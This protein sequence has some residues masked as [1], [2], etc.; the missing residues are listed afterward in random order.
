MEV[1]LAMR[2][3]NIR[4]YAY[5]VLVGLAAA[6]SG[7]PLVSDG[8]FVSVAVHAQDP[9]WQEIALD[10]SG[11]LRSKRR[12][13][14]APE[15]YKAFQLNEA[16]LAALLAEAP[17]EFTEAAKDPRN[18]IPLPMPDGKFTRFRFVE[19]PIMEPAL[20]AQF[21]GIKTYRGWSIDDPAMT[22][23][24]A[25]TSGGFHA[26]V[27]GA[28]GAAY[29]TPLSHDDTRIHVSY[30]ARDAGADG[31]AACL[32]EPGE[33][34]GPRLDG[35][36]PRR[37]GS[38]A[39]PTSNGSMLR[40]FRLAVAATGE[41]TGFFG[42]TVAGAMNNGIVP[43]INAVTAVYQR[44]LA[45]SFM[46]VGSNASIIFTDPA[47]DGYSSGNTTRL[48][49]E[50]QS[51]LDQ[52]IGAGNYD[53][54]HVFDLNSVGGQ[55]RVGSV[56]DGGDKGRGT[57]G[58]TNPTAGFPFFFDRM[59]AHEFGHQ[60]GAR[61]T[62]NGTVGSCA[63]QRN[64]D[65]AYEP[66]S[67][68]T[69]MAYAGGCGSDAVIIQ[70]D[71]SQFSVSYFHGASLETMA[72]YLNNCGCGTTTNNNN[73]LP[74][75][76][77]PFPSLGYYLIP[78]GTPFALTASATDAED[79]SLTYCWEDLDRG[80][81]GPPTGDRVD[82]PLFRS[83]PPTS[84]PTRTFPRMVDILNGT[85]TLG[86][87]LPTTDRW[88]GFRV[89]ARDNHPGGGGFAWGDVLVNVCWRSTP[90]AVTAPT[91][92]AQA[93][94]GD[95]LTVTWDAAFTNVQPINTANVRILLSTDGGA[96]FPITL[97]ASAPNNGSFTG[98]VPH[99]HTQQARIKVEAIGNIFFNVSPAFTI[100]P[101]PT[102]TASG[103]LAVTKGGPSVTAQVATVADERDAANLLTVEQIT[104]PLTGVGLSFA[105]NNGVVSATATAQCVSFGGSHSIRLRVTNSAGLSA[106]TTL[107]LTVNDDPSPTLGAYSN[108]SVI[109]GQSVTISPSAAPAD[110][111]N[112]LSGI[113]VWTTTPPLSATL[114]TDL[115]TGR[116]TIRTNNNTQTKIYEMRVEVRD[117]C[118][119][120]IT[121]GFFLTVLNSPPQITRNANSAR[122]TQGGTSAAPI[123]IATVSDLQDAAGDL[124]VSAIAPAG[125]T[126][127][128]TNSNGAVSATAIATC[129]VA[130]ATYNATLTVT[131]S[132]G[133][134]A[135]TTF[136]IIV[137][138]N[139]PPTLGVYFDSG[140][141][142]GGAVVIVPNAPPSD[143]NNA[144]GLTVTVSPQIL[145]GGGQ[146]TINPSN[147]RVTVNTVAATMLKVY[148]IKV[149]ALDACGAQ[150]TRSFNL[151]VRSAICVTEQ[152]MIFAADTGNHRIQ[153]FN[154][155][156]WNVVGPGTQGSGLGQFT[157]PESVV[158]SPDGRR[159]YVADTGNLRVQ[160]SQDGGGT[161]AV[162]ASGLIPQGLA[163]DRDGNLYVSDARD[164]L[165]LR[166]RSGIP[167]AP[168]ALATSG[169]GA[170]QVR[171]PNG[172]AIDCRMN[173]YM[174]DTGN[175]RVLVIA[176][177]DSAM[178]VITGAVLANSGVGLNPA[179]VTAPQGV[180]VD[181][182]GK[183]YVADTGNNR[184]LMMANAPAPGAAT[185]LCMPGSALG[186]VSGA[187]GVT[188]AAFAAG[189]LAGVSSISVSDTSNNRIQA[190]GL[191]VAAG[192]WRLLGG[193]PAAGTGWFTLPSKLR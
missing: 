79:A 69:I 100:I 114:S 70:S 106:E 111:N 13:Q 132:G 54:G 156:N 28:Q 58:M 110:A 193:G 185:V 60:F 78:S 3:K 86:E 16:A 73:T 152:S 168:V 153:R 45:V 92:G 138:P 2:R 164:N 102:I 21:P 122:T 6:L 85:T 141:T 154:G 64:D 42:G 12:P 25:R 167:G 10:S 32:V 147:G 88:L 48:R 112:N 74:T 184:V 33:R 62:F 84:N 107:T 115:A 187:E 26:I 75:V 82:N 94:E 134:T 169:S 126:V 71:L 72:D 9:L 36:A 131:D 18:E 129:A 1:I 93:L 149:T 51:K 15:R 24:F 41:Y 96:T 160:W 165:V 46:L 53:I 76:T 150:A 163:L 162:F 174:A 170:G 125:L 104:S 145:P 63:N 181:N 130:S 182:A 23:R 119:L 151:T 183:L 137:D 59:V 179:Q 47:T 146:V 90:F 52:I 192:S 5:F 80:S 49:D 68:S 173:L 108:T 105:N 61:H 40:T 123:A 158:A 22:T 120:A 142:V 55:A 50:N 95:S 67:G 135:S 178:L 35:G 144:V 7:V 113:T 97:A 161:W 148:P 101:K 29:I 99:A 38:A 31:G 57:S 87:T 121:Q 30:F 17:M 188:I 186:Q 136:P 103:N 98:V 37:S 77:P 39:V 109:A 159:I 172:L 117:G 56:C 4:V 65:T 176:T 118:G 180:A 139:P 11:A 191:P 190:S 140:V 27:L 43:T 189:P 143:P 81:P 175:N 8:S 133:M 89:T 66:G 19:S 127:S 83:W 128:V 166:Y 157:S 20:A 155:V 124:R 171:N 14:R 34:V 44:D 177:A 91:A 116:V